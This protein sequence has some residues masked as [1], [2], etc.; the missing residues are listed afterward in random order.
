MSGVER[1]ASHAEMQPEP[2]YRVGRDVLVEVEIAR[3]VNDDRRAAR[4]AVVVRDVA[5]SGRRDSVR[6]SADPCQD[7][8]SLLLPDCKVLVSTFDGDVTV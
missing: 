3:K 8:V 1:R 2:A 7:H 5:P 6:S 4:R